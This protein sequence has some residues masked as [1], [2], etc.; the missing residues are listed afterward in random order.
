MSRAGRLASLL[1]VVAITA[2]HDL[3][4]IKPDDPPPVSPPQ[5]VSVTIEYRQLNGCYDPSGPCNDKV[6]FFGSWMRPGTEFALT[7]DPGNFVWRGVA[8]GVPVNFPPRD[9]PYSVRI[10]DPYLRASSS[11]GFT[12]ERLKVGGESLTVIDSIGGP[13]ENGLVYIDE[14]GRG[15]NPF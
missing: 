8:Q 6:I 11:I 2:C 9:F 14:N 3:R 1:S 4:L 13:D 10:F 7:P 5:L 12:A 15:H